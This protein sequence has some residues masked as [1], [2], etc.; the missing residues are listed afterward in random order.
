MAS[1]IQELHKQGQ[2]LWLD[3]IRRQLITSGELARLLDDGLRGVTS[4]PSIFEKAV[5]GSTD[6]DEALVR[7]VKAGRKPD[8]ILWDL[9]IEDVQAAAD[10]F[11]PV[12]DESRGG[13]GFVSIEVGPA[14]AYDTKR[15]IKVARELHRRTARPNVMVKIPATREGLPA[16]RQMIAEGQNINI[17]LIF[18]VARYAE[19]VEQYFSGLEE[20]KAKGGD[21]SQVASVASF[22]VS[23]IDSKVDK[24]LEE[25]IDKER[26]PRRQDDMRRLLGKTGI[27]NSKMAYQ[28]FKQLHSGSRWRE[29]EEAGA[30]PQR[31]LWAS[32][33]T[34]NPSYPDTMYVEELIGPDTVD[35]VPPNTLA[36]F[37]EHG[38]VRAS[39]VEN[40][41][42]ARRQLDQLEA[43]GVDLSQVT[44]EV[45]VEGVDAFIKSYE[46]LLKTL[47]D[48][49]KAIQQGRGPRQW[50][51]LGRL[52]PALDET[53]K[54][55]Q[56]KEAPR[57]LWAK[58]STLWTDDRE[59]RQEV[60]NRLGWLDVAGKMLDEK[61][62][63]EQLA[64]EARV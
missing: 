14:E 53:V 42:L 50:H 3:N 15:T 52:Q 10:V 63:F 38:E 64:K 13:D 6:Y 59:K 1:A 12:F 31:P 34:K 11:R 40:L 29:L 8:D 57:K 58:D 46:S 51:S 43:L 16:I 41:A 62:R 61:S 49:A 30:R 35:T 56:E 33:S 2:S 27:N 48:T 9:I 19:V 5:S 4:N 44:R 24:L 47:R 20:F 54:K 21:L 26:D 7:L 37:R 18:S 36:A 25:K 60:R 28:V 23:R 17:T 45:E 39:L 22:F 55:L 32:T